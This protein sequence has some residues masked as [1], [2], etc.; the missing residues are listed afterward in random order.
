MLPRHLCC[1]LAAVLAFVLLD[2]SVHRGNS[3]LDMAPDRRARVVKRDLDMTVENEKTYYLAWVKIGSDQQEIGVLV[4]TGSSDLWVPEVNCISNPDLLTRNLQS[5]DSTF[6]ERELALPV[7]ERDSTSTDVC[8]GYGA[9]GMFDPSS[10]TSFQWNDTKHSFYAAYGD[11]TWGYGSWGNDDVDVLGL[12]VKGLSFGVC[13]NVETT[14]VF[15]IGLPGLET[16][17]G[18]IN[19]YQYY[20]HIPNDELYTY[21]NFPALLKTQ[22]ATQLN[23]YSVSLGLN[24]PQEGSVLFGAVDHSKYNGT[25]Q[26]VKM[27]NRLV[28]LGYDNPILSEIILDS[29]TGHKLKE[30]FQTS[31]LLD[32]GST[33][34]SMPQVYIDAIGKHLKGT[35]TQNYYEVDCGLKTLTEQIVFSF[36]GI[37]ISTPISSFIID[38]NVQGTCLLGLQLSDDSLGILGDDF[39]R[40]VYAVYDLDN[41]E[42]ALAPAASDNSASASIEEITS[43]IPGATEAPNYS[44][45]LLSQVVDINLSLGTFVVTQSSSS[46]STASSSSSAKKLGAVRTA[47]VGISLIGA[48]ALGA[49]LIC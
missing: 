40:N 32:S 22:G 6:E 14:G 26:K 10:L 45:T 28:N 43:G 41:Y 42:I 11:G 7:D 46:Q 30:E 5:G 31:V 35:V 39:L 8:S 19:N 34:S 47:K 20:S 17:D 49:L 36:S 23:S 4:D 25:L 27:S 1:Y 48:V 44:S 2:F 38:S 16:S 33:M 18:N 24:D 15:G 21:E 9:M 12:T 29:V 37:E 13:S 3:P